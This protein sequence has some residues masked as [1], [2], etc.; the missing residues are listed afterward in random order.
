MKKF[1]QILLILLCAFL[2]AK[3]FATSSADQ[4]LPYPSDFFKNDK[5]L[6][7]VLKNQQIK[8][9]VEIGCWLG[10]STVFMAC[11]LP[12][13]GKLY[14]IDSWIG[15]PREIY[16]ITRNVYEQ[17]LTNI[18]YAGLSDK[19]IP[20]RMTSLSASR[21]FSKY[22]KRVDMIYIDG[23]HA[24]EAVYSDIQAW[25]FYVKK[26]GILCGNFY[27]KNDEEMLQIKKAVQDYCIA[28]GKTASFEGYFWRIH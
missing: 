1:T 10:E 5:E 12:S 17:F 6:S 25:S 7:A 14:A 13:D 22:C 19:V 24:Y 26:G 27:A 28:K 15:Y 18:T 8:T 11:R 21:I 9:I 20:I 16:E 4:K 2:D 3:T 23:D